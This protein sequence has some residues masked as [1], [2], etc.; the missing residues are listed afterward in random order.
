MEKQFSCSNMVIDLTFCPL[1]KYF[2]PLAT[3]C[4]LP[5]LAGDT[6]Y[7]SMV[8]YIAARLF[9]VKRRK[10]FDF[11]PIFASRKYSSINIGKID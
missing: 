10:F 11:C 3:F 5:I 6:L 7:P 1:E 8:H 9:S 4:E 2:E